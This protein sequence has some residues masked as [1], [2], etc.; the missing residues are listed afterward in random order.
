[1]SSAGNMQRDQS[2]LHLRPLDSEENDV[3]NDLVFY[4]YR[5]A[6][7]HHDGSVRLAGDGHDGA[8][9]KCEACGNTVSLEWDGGVA[10]DVVLISTN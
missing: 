4:S 5:C 2:R 10:F 8:Q 7:C 3:D 6:E 9:S 1:M